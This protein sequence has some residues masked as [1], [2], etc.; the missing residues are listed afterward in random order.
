M[1]D[2]HFLPHDTSFGLDIPELE[3][4]GNLQ[5]PLAVEWA[6]AAIK[7]DVHNPDSKAL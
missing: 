4:W 1:T 7:Q 2:N 3:L 5:V 6:L